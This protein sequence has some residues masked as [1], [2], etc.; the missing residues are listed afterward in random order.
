L[1]ARGA[2]V[3]HSIKQQVSEDGAKMESNDIEV[4]GIHHVG[5]PVAE[6]ERALAFYVGVLGMEH[7]AAPKGFA[8]G[9]RWLRIGN[10]HVHLIRATEGFGP[11]GPRHIAFH[12]KDVK[13]SAERLK[14]QGFKLD[15]A[16]F[17]DGAKRF[18]VKD[19]DENSLEFI[20][21]FIDWDDGTKQ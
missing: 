16:P 1:F 20:Q 11:Q 17:I 5:L 18:Y 21:W 7:I 10:Q 8:A 12:V 19:P 3:L 9:V 13:A 2:R 14:A 4:T 6:F 15:E